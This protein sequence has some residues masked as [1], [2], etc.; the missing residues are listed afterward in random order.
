MDVNTKKSWTLICDPGKNQAFWQF[1]TYQATKES[2]NQ[3]WGLHEDFLFKVLLNTGVIA[4]KWV[5]D[6]FPTLVGVKR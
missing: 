5:L 4:R 1:E 6:V 3:A 2:K